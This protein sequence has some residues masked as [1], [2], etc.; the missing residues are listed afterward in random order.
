MKLNAPTLEYVCDIE[1]ALGPVHEMGNGRAGQRR[2]IPIVGGVVIGPRINGRV[3]DVGA[4]WQT[5]IDGNLT[6]LDTRYALET[7]DGA[8]IEIINYGYRFGSPDVLK[9]LAEGEEVSPDQY[10]M[11]TQARLETGDPRYR[12]VNHM[13]FVGTGARHKS[14]VTTALYAIG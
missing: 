5:V 6:E 14:A 7:N 11:R 4:D 3:L 10:Y 1:V 9:K 13:L 12:W 8:T 2:I